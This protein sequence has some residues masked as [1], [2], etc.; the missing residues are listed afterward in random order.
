[1]INVNALLTDHRNLSGAWKAPRP[2]GQLLLTAI[3]A[4]AGAPDSPNPFEQV[5]KALAGATLW[6]YRSQ[7]WALVASTNSF[8]EHGSCQTQI[9]GFART[10]H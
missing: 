10:L 8:Q 2:R 3:R 9:L 7:V 5:R 4:I 6:W 1:M